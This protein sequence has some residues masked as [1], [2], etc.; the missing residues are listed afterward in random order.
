M[1]LLLELVLKEFHVVVYSKVD[2]SSICPCM[3]EYSDEYN[4]LANYSSAAGRHIETPF[5]IIS[6]GP[7]WSVAIG[8]VP[9]AMPSIIANPKYSSQVEPGKCCEFKRGGK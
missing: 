7:V 1:R 8:T 6:L 3:F 5:V 9:H 4:G 2:I